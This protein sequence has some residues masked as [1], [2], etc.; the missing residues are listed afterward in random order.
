MKK[1]MKG[2]SLYPL[3]LNYEPPEKKCQGKIKAL[4]KI[5][6]KWNERLK[7]LSREELLMEAEEI[8]K[9]LGL[10][11][12]IDEEPAEVLKAY[13]QM[14]KEQR[15]QSGAPTRKTKSKSR[16]IDDM[17]EFLKKKKSHSFRRER[18]RKGVAAA[19][20]AI[21]CVASASMTSEANRQWVI[22]RV[23]YA[24]GDD[25][26]VIQV[27]DDKEKDED[28]KI[29]EINKEIEEVLGVE[30][31]KFAYLPSEFVFDDYELDKENMIAIVSYKYNGANIFFRIGNGEKENTH[32]V[33]PHGEIK[34]EGY[35]ENDV[36]TISSFSC[37]DKNGTISYLAEWKYENGYY[38]L[39]GPLEKKTFE[40]ILK[41]MR[42]YV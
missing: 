2:V 36:V 28:W 7:N 8:E 27:S 5:M 10:P 39:V 35:V 19:C 11:S 40:K 9:E 29:D 32:F 23:Q 30:V 41:K 20:L 34:E 33:R 3:Y 15:M 6:D 4:K 18:I 38:Q 12:E 42:Y 25:E 13:E 21:L 16:G 37:Y 24:V 17:P 14:K 22:E 31:P 1:R 26:M